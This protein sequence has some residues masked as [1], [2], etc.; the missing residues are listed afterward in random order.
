MCVVYTTL[1]LSPLVLKVVSS[2]L[3]LFK[4]LLRIT[5]EP[6]SLFFAMFITT[7]NTL[8]KRKQFYIQTNSLNIA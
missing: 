5:Q 7:M 3:M 2:S 4:K 1:V 8:H 6:Q